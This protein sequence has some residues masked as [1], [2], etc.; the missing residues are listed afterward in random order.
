MLSQITKKMEAKIVTKNIL[1]LL[2]AL[3]SLSNIAA[4]SQSITPKYL[5]FDNSKDNIIVLDKI[6][7][8]KIDK[9][10]FNIDRYNQIDTVHKKETKKIKFSSVKKLWIEGK[11]LFH[12]VS[13]NRNLFIETYNEIFEKIY[14]IEK[15]SDCKYKRTRVWWVD[16]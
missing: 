12:K 2:V 4:Q 7:Y 11:A 15:I 9:N 8:Y 13:E 5:F 14:I 6:R 16:Y 3:C 1:Y 10:L